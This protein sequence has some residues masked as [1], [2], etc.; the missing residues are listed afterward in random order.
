[1]KFINLSVVA[2]TIFLAASPV[3]G[4][5]LSFMPMGTQLDSDPIL[6]I[7]TQV[8][9]PIQFTVKLDTNGLSNPLATLQYQVIRDTTEL[10]LINFTLSTE[11][12]LYFDPSLLQVSIV[13]NG[14]E[15][16]A[17]ILYEKYANGTG[18]PVNTILNLETVFYQV[19]PG[20]IN[21]GLSDR[22]IILTSAFD[23]NGTDVTNLFDNPNQ[24]STNIDLQPEPVPEPSNLL[25]L[26]LVAGLG[27]LLRNQK[28][29]TH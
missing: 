20:L 12:Q 10:N 5:S 27:A 4:A 9:D 16:I 26:G 24:P 28:K 2:T 8:G 19:A 15:D 14:N 1:M 11:E 3:W 22:R 25:G 13:T 18:V 29:R 7:A 23:T 17:T 6:D 21:D